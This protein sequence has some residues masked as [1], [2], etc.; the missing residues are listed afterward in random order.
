VS[1]TS[2]RISA[3]VVL[4]V[5]IRHAYNHGQR[6]MAQLAMYALG[7]FF[8]YAT[9]YFVAAKLLL[10]EIGLTPSYIEIIAYPVWLLLIVSLLFALVTARVRLPANVL[11]LVPKP[12][13]TH[14]SRS[15]PN[16]A[17]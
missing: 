2:L 1:G 9:T 8:A 14:A 10:R 7:L 6:R 16:S 3:L 12:R 17:F 11:K 5:S 4:V 13:T 15:V